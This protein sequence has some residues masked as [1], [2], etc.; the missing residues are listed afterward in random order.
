ME[1]PGTRPFT[2]AEAMEIVQKF[3]RASDIC[4]PLDPNKKKEKAGRSQERTPNRLNSDCYGRERFRSPMGPPRDEGR[5]Q[6]HAQAYLIYEARDN[7]ESPF[8]RSQKDMFYSF[9][10]QLLI[11]PKVSTSQNRRNMNLW[12]EY[13]KEYD[14]TLS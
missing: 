4:T 11:P 5:R 10:E 9:R 12:C 3:I 1:A 7:G 2:Y 8:N 13:H 14:H 6:A